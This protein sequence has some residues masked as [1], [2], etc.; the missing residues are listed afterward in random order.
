VD[1][2]AADHDELLLASDLCSGGDQVLE[3]ARFIAPR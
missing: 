3:G 2:L 1:S